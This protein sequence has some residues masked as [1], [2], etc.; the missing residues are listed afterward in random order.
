MEPDASIREA[1]KPLHIVLLDYRDVTHP[2]A[3]GAET[4]L[5]E[6]FQRVSQRG[7]R[8]TLVCA[9]YRGAPREDRIGAIRVLRTGNK[10]TANLAVARAALALDRTERVDLY[11]ENI[12]KIPFLLPMFTN[13]PV[14]PIVLHL[15]GHTVF[16]ETNLAFGLYIWLYEKLIPPC[17]RGLRCVALSQSTAQNLM[18]RGLRASAIDVVPPG[19]D[20]AAYSNGAASRSEH[21]LI[22][23]VGRLK[24]YKQIEIV[25]RA[26]ARLRQTL[27]AAQLAIIGKGDDRPRLEAVVRS[28]GLE[29]SVVFTGYVSEEAKIEWLSR[30]HVAVYPS[31]REGWGISAVEAAACGTPV[32]ASDSEGLREAVRDG[33][34]G[35]LVPHL[36]VD[37]WVDRMVEVLSQRPLHHRLSAGARQWASSFDWDAQA[38]KIT[39][40][41]EEVAGGVRSA[42]TAGGA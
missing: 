19:L 22:V 16:Y 10:A 33:V 34:S 36:E 14:L 18:T 6:L 38:A 40:I 3:G 13:R 25:L 37:A 41:A 23:Y 27:P 2:E 32:L 4:Y 9:G 5:N 15:F 1:A 11:V 29:R 31:P 24:R 12:C 30:A 7:H 42:N 35:F 8:I 17:Y 20:L 26:F 39:S 21:P 28:L